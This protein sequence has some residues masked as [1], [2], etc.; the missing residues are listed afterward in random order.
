[1]HYLNCALINESYNPH[2]I[3]TIYSYNT[4][5]N[6]CRPCVYFLKEAGPWTGKINI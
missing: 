1:M 6:K 5:T 2:I 3:Q 4:K